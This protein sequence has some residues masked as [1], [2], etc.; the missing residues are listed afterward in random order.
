M[1]AESCGLIACPL[2]AAGQR[3]AAA[4][5]RTACSTWRCSVRWRWQVVW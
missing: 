1:R 5:M 3:P 2:G 4:Q